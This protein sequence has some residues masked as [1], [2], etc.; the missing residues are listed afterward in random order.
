MGQLRI[1]RVARLKQT[2]QLLWRDACARFAIAL[3][4]NL[5]DVRVVLHRVMGAGRYRNS[6]GVHDLQ[7]FADGIP[8]KALKAILEDCCDF[9][10]ARFPSSNRVQKPRPR[11]DKGLRSRT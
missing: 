4:E 6:G 3:Q 2:T 7:P 1:E 10:L 11:G 9:F 5:P 8:L